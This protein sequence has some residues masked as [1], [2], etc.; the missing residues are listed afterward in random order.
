[1]HGFHRSPSKSANERH[2]GSGVR[3]PEIPSAPGTPPKA[4]RLGG[5]RAW[6]SQSLDHHF[7]HIVCRGRD[8]A[9][10]I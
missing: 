3:E 5:H 2:T 4:Q 6:P 10:Q 9:K 1:M 7:G 8:L